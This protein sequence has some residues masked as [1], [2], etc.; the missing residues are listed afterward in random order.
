MLKSV[1]VEVENRKKRKDEKRA[2]VGGG[3]IN[4]LIQS[5]VEERGKD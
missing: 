1:D 2:E 4:P 3:T 5:S